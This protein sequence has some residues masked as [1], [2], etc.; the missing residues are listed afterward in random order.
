MT[1]CGHN[2]WYCLVTSFSCIAKHLKSTLNCPLCKLD[3]S[4]NDIFPNFLLDKLIH[5]QNTQIDPVNSFE[6]SK[7]LETLKNKKQR[8]DNGSEQLQLS[9]FQAFLN[10]TKAEK[11]TVLVINQALEKLNRE[12]KYLEDDY[13]LVD[14]I[15]R[16]NHPPVNSEFQENITL[17][18]AQVPQ[19]SNNSS[20]K[21]QIT[22][23]DVLCYKD[24]INVQT[25]EHQVYRLNAH[26]VDL[27][28][29]YF[30]WRNSCNYD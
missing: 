9:L 23:E 4:N 2:Y 19:S 11:I 25:K 27:Q 18:F 12:I 17:P 3:I 13:N 29:S 5:K 1:K 15:L 6:I 7:A 28:N 10:K 14:D 20:L 16:K 21:R 26:I 30:S 24:N 8:L 22:D